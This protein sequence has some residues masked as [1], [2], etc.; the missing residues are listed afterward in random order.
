MNPEPLASLPASLLLL[1]SLPL[2]RKL[3][4]LE[5]LFG[6]RLA[7]KGIAEV[8]LANGCVWT[9][10][11]GEVTHRWMV[12]GAYEGPVQMNWLK[13]WLKNGGVFIDSGANIGQFIVSLSASPGLRTFAFEPVCDQRRWL[14]GCLCRYPQWDVSVIPLGL[15]D[16]EQQAM[17][18]LAG[19]RSTLRQDWYQGRQLTQELIELTTLDQ[20]ASREGIDRIRLWKLDMEGYEPKA[21]AGAQ[22]LLAQRRIDALLIEAQTA[23]IPRIVEIFSAAGYGLYR[24]QGS[25]SLSAI[26]ESVWAGGFE[27]N[28][29]A[30]PHGS[31]R[32]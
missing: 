4:L 6:G 8:S 23:T 22:Q 9:I 29:I 20:F 5:R 27:G 3:G 14:E 11:F 28:L 15:G 24:L 10:D 13:G 2:P 19:G 25:G 32:L 17:I 1:R 7:S 12:Y 18:K 16:D 21:L 26:T 30:L 31:G